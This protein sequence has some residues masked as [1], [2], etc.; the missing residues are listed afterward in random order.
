MYTRRLTLPP[1]RFLLLG[2]RG[3]GKTTWLRR[4]LPQAQWYNLLLDRELLRLMREPGAFRRE[5]EALPK[6]AWVVIDEV[7]KLP[8]LLNEVHDALT[9][10]PKRWN[11][12]L[13]GSSARRLRRAEVNLLGGRV[14]MRQMLPLTAAEIGRAPEVS[15]LLRFGGLPIVC[16]EKS[17]S[18][19]IDLLEAY[20]ETYLTQEIRA[21]ALVRSLEGFTRFLEVAALANAQVT[22]VA[23]LA[24]DAAVARPTVQGYFE[25][26]TDTL[27]GAWLPAWRPRAKVK[28]AAHPKFYLFDCGVAR[29]LA[30]RL[31]EPLDAAE[32]GTLL[33]TLVFHELRAQMAYAAIGGELAYYRTPS[34]TEIDF[35]WTRARSAIGIEVKASERWRP[36]FARAFHELHANGVIR[37]AFGV[38]LGDR[39]LQDGAVRVLPVAAFLREL[40]GGRVLVTAR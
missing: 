39:P 16:A 15:E 28:E 35:I 1:R 40:A 37:R 20:V 25:V 18:G 7:Q 24:R 4:H 21:E 6:G 5:I 34:G 8:S 26:L 31:R 33:E 29:A 19:R 3:T 11:F 38:Y 10:Q 23:S 17:A 30:R 14:V 22:N 36:E 12:A 27:L 13:S 2:P 9:A 32:R